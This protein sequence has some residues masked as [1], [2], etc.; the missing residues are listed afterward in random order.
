M[1]FSVGFV[2]LLYLRVA[3]I[4]VPGRASTPP[5][6]VEASLKQVLVVELVRFKSRLLGKLKVIREFALKRAAQ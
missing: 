6:A 5:I 1:V 4:A 2:R 3:S